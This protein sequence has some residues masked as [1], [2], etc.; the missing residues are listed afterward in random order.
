MK[1]E[2]KKEPLILDQVRKI[3]KLTKLHLLMGALIDIKQYAREI[4]ELKEKGMILL[5]EIGI[6]E[7][8]RKKI[9][10]FINSLPEIRLSEQDKKD[11]RDRMRDKVKTARQETEKKIKDEPLRF[12]GDLT[13]YE[14]YRTYTTP[15]ALSFNATDGSNLQIKI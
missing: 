3:E 11:M 2:T 9:I 4:L 8:D 7:E 12:A 14:G 13:N 1:K 15:N 10:D 6:S 5:E